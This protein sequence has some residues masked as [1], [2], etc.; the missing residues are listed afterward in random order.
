LLLPLIAVEVLEDDVIDKFPGFAS[1]CS[2]FLKTA[3]LGEEYLLY[4]D[5]C[6]RHGI[7]VWRSVTRSAGARPEYMLDENEVSLA[8]RL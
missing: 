5:G 4:G 6:W 8:V 7:D 1:V 3:G 2:G